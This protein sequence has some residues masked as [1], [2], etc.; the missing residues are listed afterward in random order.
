MTAVRN[1]IGYILLSED[2]KQSTPASK[3]CDE[4]CLDRLSIFS[5]FRSKCV[6]YS[7]TVTRHSSNRDSCTYTHTHTH[8]HTHK[9]KASISLAPCSRYAESKES[10]I[11]RLLHRRTPNSSTSCTTDL[12]RITSCTVSLVQRKELLPTLA[13]EQAATDLQHCSILHKR[14]HHSVVYVHPSSL[15]LL[16]QGLFHLLSQQLEMLP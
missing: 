8:T 3:S 1:C 9:G 7:W 6:A 5:C 15:H 12:G 10:I 4:S 16:P 14:C 13:Y 2:E 11:T